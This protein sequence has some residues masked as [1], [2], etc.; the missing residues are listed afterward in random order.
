M[1]QEYADALIRIAEDETVT[2]PDDVEIVAWDTNGY[3][4]SSPHLPGYVLV[5]PG[6]TI[7]MPSGEA[8]LCEAI[9]A[10]LTARART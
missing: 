2:F 8:D 1:R 6:A 4:V 9:A 5:H 3:R 7:R 10:F